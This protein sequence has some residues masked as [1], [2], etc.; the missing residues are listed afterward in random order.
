MAQWV[1]LAG[2]GLKG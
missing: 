1:V 2:A